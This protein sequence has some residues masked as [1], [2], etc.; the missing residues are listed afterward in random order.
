MKLQ[1]DT[2]KKTIQIIEDINLGELIK[3]LKGMLGEDY[4]EYLLLNGNMTYTYYPWINP[5]IIPYSIPTWPS[6]TC[7]TGTYNVEVVST[8]F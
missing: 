7:S 2:N 1:I 4:K 8:K 3:A 6:I 5:I